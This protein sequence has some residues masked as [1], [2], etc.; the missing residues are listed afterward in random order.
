MAGKEGGLHVY[1]QKI[2]T[3]TGSMT[4]IVLPTSLVKRMTAT[5]TMPQCNEKLAQ[6]IDSQTVDE[7]VVIS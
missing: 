4:L 1:S 3:T 6:A 7:D 2:N 5:R